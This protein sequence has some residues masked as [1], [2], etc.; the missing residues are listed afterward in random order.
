MFTVGMWQYLT[1]VCSIKTTHW[2]RRGFSLL[3]TGVWQYL[4]LVC[5]MFIMVVW[6]YLS[7]VC[8]I[9][10]QCVVVVNQCLRSVPG[11]VFLLQYVVY[12]SSMQCLTLVYSIKTNPWARRWCSMLFTGVW[13]Y[14]TL[15][16]SILLQ[17]VVSY[18]SMQHKN[19]SMGKARVQYAVY[20]CVVVSQSSVQYLTLACS[21][22]LQYVA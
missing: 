8:S 11:V 4:T 10:V 1:L 16:C 14:L 7:I 2:A 9:L 17:Y 21:I 20:G 19:K 12:Y 22:L 6:Y 13:Q 18:S 15:V 5:S 3:F